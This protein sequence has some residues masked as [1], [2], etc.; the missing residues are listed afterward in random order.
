MMT[1]DELKFLEAVGY[2][3]YASARQAQDP[4]LRQARDPADAVTLPGAW[5]Q[6]AT[7][8]LSR[9]RG[10]PAGDEI[11]DGL[12][13]VF[14]LFWQAAAPLDR[15]RRGGVAGRIAGGGDGRPDRQ[16]ERQIGGYARA[17]PGSPWSG[18]GAGA[19]PRRLERRSGRGAEHEILGGAGGRAPRA[20]APL[21]P[22]AHG[23]KDLD[24]TPDAEPDLLADDTGDE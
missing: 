7:R 16:R 20:V 15:N 5:V 1:K 12:R 4:A 17:T 21:R 8:A 11:L 3:G 13:V 22:D 19:F 2:G 6:S 23:P 24:L 18:L 14:D 10:F 9:A